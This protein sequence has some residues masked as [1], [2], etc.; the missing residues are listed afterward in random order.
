[1][2]PQTPGRSVSAGFTPLPHSLYNLLLPT[3]QQEWGTAPPRLAESPGTGPAFP[4]GSESTPG[5]PRADRSPSTVGGHRSAVKD[6]RT[7]ATEAEVRTRTGSPEGLRTVPV[8]WRR[9]PS[10]AHLG[11]VRRI[12][13]AL[14]R[15][16]LDGEELSKTHEGLFQGHLGRAALGSLFRP[17]L[18][19]G[20]AREAWERGRRGSRF[21]G[22]QEAPAG[23]LPPERS[24]RPPPSAG[25][26][27]PGTPTAPTDQACQLGPQF[28][29]GRVGAAATPALATCRLGRE[30]RDL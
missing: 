11:Q 19:L 30:Q 16:Q 18:G 9:I 6:T 27:P 13:E 5:E 7:R 28:R 2:G 15:P 4:W 25:G 3:H 8:G 24:R 29:R 21:T 12:P 20:A 1:M 10:P 23:P 17:I 22:R 26:S 14:F